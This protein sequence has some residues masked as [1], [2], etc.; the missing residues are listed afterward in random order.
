MKHFI[1]L[2]LLILSGSLVASVEDLRFL[3]ETYKPFLS[4]DPYYKGL[5]P[6]SGAIAWHSGWI[7]MFHLKR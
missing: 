6:L 7:K 4:K 5:S 2:G 3:K 1:I